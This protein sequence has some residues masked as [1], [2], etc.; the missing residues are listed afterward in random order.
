MAH[1]VEPANVW[2]WAAVFGWAVRQ[3][4]NDFI[5]AATMVIRVQSYML[6]LYEIDR[7]RLEDDT[8]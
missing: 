2:A 8:P 4:F 7:A 1:P 3:Q 6:D 5:R